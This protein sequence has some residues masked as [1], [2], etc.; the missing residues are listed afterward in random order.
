MRRSSRSRSRPIGAG[1]MDRC[2]QSE[3][4]PL[5]SRLSHPRGL[6]GN[7]H[8]NERSAPQPRP[9][10]PIARCFPGAHAPISTRDSSPGWMNFRG[11]NTWNRVD[12]R[13]SWVLSNSSRADGLSSSRAAVSRLPDKHEDRTKSLID[14]ARREGPLEAADVEFI[15][16]PDDSPGI[17]LRTE[18]ISMRTPACD[19]CASPIA[20]SALNEPTAT[21]QCAVSRLNGGGSR[22]SDYGDA[23]RKPRLKIQYCCNSGTLE[24]K[25]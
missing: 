20:D 23:G 13:G 25:M 7:L 14:A 2:I 3:P 17:R 16:T 21:V 1:A 18:E 5:S 10:P 24:L 8:R 12:T 4:P 6:R 9:A 11:H 15:G 19:S 22:N